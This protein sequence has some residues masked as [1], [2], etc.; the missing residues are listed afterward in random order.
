M[1]VLRVPP[2]PIQIT[3]DV[4][5]ASTE[6][7]LEIQDMVDLSTTT[8]DVTSTTGKKVTLSLTGDYVKYDN[9]Y[10]INIYTDNAGEL[11]NIVVTD[12]LDI[13]RPYVDPTTYSDI[14][15]EQTD[16]QYNERIA[17]S[18]IDSITDGFYN[19]K[20]IYE[21]T[22]LGG[23]FMHLIPRANKILQVYENNVLVYDVNDLENSTQ[24]FEITKD[25]TAIVYQYSDEINRSEGAPLIFPS[26][27]G[28]IVDYGFWTTDT[29]PNGYDYTF[30]LEAGYPVV[31]LDIQDATKMLID[32][33]KCGKLDYY[34][35][36][37]GQYN[38]DQFRLQYDKKVFDGTG[39]LI[40]DKILEKYQEP[41]F[42]AGVL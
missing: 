8:I 24:L 15:S 35:R 26:S 17:R 42:N 22:G 31:P 40:V 29:F 11:G 23:D 7:H 33:L 41:M 32:D 21:R 28:D 10:L 3:Y 9:S 16:Y 13:T 1:I 19:K 14:A 36:Y 37:V 5:N 34:K 30:I 20:V 4:P 38:T 12:S 6:Y 2:Y 27:N 25:G 39:N 18:L